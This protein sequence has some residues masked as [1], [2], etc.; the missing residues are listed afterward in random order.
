MIKCGTHQ[1]LFWILIQ[2]HKMRHAPF[3]AQM[4]LKCRSQF[5]N[6]NINWSNQCQKMNWKLQLRSVKYENLFK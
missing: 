6:F 3:P 4:I 5:L 1:L 2:V